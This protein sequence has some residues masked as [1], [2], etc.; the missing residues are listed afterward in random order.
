M[1]F[2]PLELPDVLLVEPD[3]FEDSRG[4]FLE[5]WHAEKYAAAGVDAMFVQDNQSRSVRGTLRG[6]HAQLDPAQGKL[7]RVLAG[8]IFDVAVDI[9][10]GSPTFGSYASATISAESFHQIWIPAGFAHGFCVTSEV[11][12][13]EYK[14]TAPWRREGEIAIAWDDPRIGIPWPCEEPTLSKRDGAAPPLAE[15]EDALPVYRV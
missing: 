14:V 9:R 13:V 3:V 11:A 10:R 5:T 7:V 6:L 12:D 8:E 1:K 15:L 2:T 4:Y